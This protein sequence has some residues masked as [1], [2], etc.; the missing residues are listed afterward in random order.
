MAGQCDVEILSKHVRH[1]N[2]KFFSLFSDYIEIIDKSRWYV[3]PIDKIQF[4]LFCNTYIKEVVVTEPSIIKINDSCVLRNNYMTLR[5]FKEILSQRVTFL[6]SLNFTTPNISAVELPKLHLISNEYKDLLKDA[7]DLRIVAEK[8]DKLKREHRSTRWY[9]FSMDILSCVGYSSILI[10]IIII[11]VKIGLCGAFCFCF[12]RLFVKCWNYICCKPCQINYYNNVF[13]A[14]APTVM[15]TY[16]AP[17]SESVV[18]IDNQNVRT[19]S[20]QNDNQNARTLLSRSN[21]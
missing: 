12:K 13:S 20:A 5:P 10:L 4:S 7:D 6:E 11:C 16:N 19:L 1:C 17:A 3:V 8:L 2:Y 9:S 15:A 14:Q 18:R 21:M